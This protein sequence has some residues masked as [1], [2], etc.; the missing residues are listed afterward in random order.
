[1][2]VS[3]VIGAALVGRCDWA[4]AQLV[5]RCGLEELPLGTATA[6]TSPDL[7]NARGPLLLLVCGSE[8][9]GAAG[10]WGRSLLINEGA[11]SGAMFEYV[12]RAQSLGWSVVVADPHGDESP[13]AHMQR[14]WH[15]AIAPAAAAHVLC[16]AHSYGG[17]WRARCSR[18][19]RRRR[20]RGS[21]RSR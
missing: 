9:G 13:H 14:L 11:R 8:P 6:Y 4:Q 19:C 16:V 20:A 18:A 21:R 7:A 1:M 12:S 15:A 10:V 3:L 17:R 2:L 5:T